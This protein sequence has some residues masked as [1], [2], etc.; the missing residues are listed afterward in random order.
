MASV[1]VGVTI[2]VGLLV[3]L[4]MYWGLSRSDWAAW[5]QAVGSIAAV[6]IAVF[7]VRVQHNHDIMQRRL[8]DQSIRRRQLACLRWVFTAIAE[9][10]ERVS[11]EVH[12][13]HVAWSMEARHLQ[14]RRN[15]L[16]SIGLADFPDASLLLRAQEL[17]EQLQIAQ[18]VTDALV[19]PRNEEILNKVAEILRSTRDAALVGVT[20]TTQLLV[21]CSS[22]QELD[23]DWAI[24]DARKKNFELT[25]RILREV[26]A[27]GSESKGS[28]SIEN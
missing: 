18:D 7:I 11:N 25:Q 3:W 8:Q 12:N 5:V 1:I 17:S 10:C 15:M 4:G 14:N 13:P 21:R 6:L 24:L 2:S 16:T 22:P 19:Q 20:E 9:T 23:E 26:Q 28:E 27:R